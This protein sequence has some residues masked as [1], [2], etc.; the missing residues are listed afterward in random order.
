MYILRQNIFIFLILKNEFPRHFCY[1]INIV[2]K[3]SK[4]KFVHFLR[5]SFDI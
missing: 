2:D 3:Y 1:T 4:I 5:S